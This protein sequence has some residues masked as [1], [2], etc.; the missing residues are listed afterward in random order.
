MVVS[1]HATV[2]RWCTAIGALVLVGVLVAGTA[3]AQSRDVRVD[4][5]V[6]ALETA[7]R[8]TCDDF[9]AGHLSESYL[10]ATSPADLGELCGRLAS[11]AGQAGGAGF[12]IHG[13]RYQLTLGGPE[14]R[15]AI[16][17]TVS[18]T[19]PFAVDT[20]SIEDANANLSLPEITR[21]NIDQVLT[22]V[23]NA[24]FDGVVYA[25]VD[26]EVLAERPLGFADRSRK[27]EMTVDKIF[28]VGSQPIDYTTALARIAD[29]RGLLDLDAPIGRYVG[30]VPADKARM[31][32][33][34]L[35]D[36]VSGLPDFIDNDSDWDPDLAWITR[37]E[38]IRRVLAA[39]LRF[40]P[41]ARHAHSHA[42]YSFLAAIVEI[43]ADKPYFEYLKDKILEPASMTHTGM[44]GDSGEFAVE[45]FAVGGGPSMIGLPN[46]PPNWGPTS[47]LVKGS[48]GMYSTLDDIV[49]FVRF[50]Q[51]DDS[52]PAEVRAQ[53]SGEAV[54]FNGSMRGFEMFE[55]RN[56]SDDLILVFS[57]SAMGNKTYRDLAQRLEQFGSRR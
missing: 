42:G 7:H 28:G 31:T 26:G 52:M 16:I 45:D 12:E 40:E 1:R 6:K 34:H 48:G 14:G 56:G 39:P 50:V 4:Q 41:G 8:M 5:H 15:F 33:R 2:D 54:N 17:F 25:R 24:G 22:M 20:I 23:E 3:H 38:F 53:F 18:D 10:E 36:S 29:A 11:I 57:N 13:E 27:G 30:E 47:W 32:V 51:T 44:Y 49:K 46:I 43:A 19:P 37:E 35:L 55:Y 9:A 21:D